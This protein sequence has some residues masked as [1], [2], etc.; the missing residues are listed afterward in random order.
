MDEPREQ[1]NQEAAANLTLRVVRGPTSKASDD[2]WRVRSDRL[3]AWLLSEWER[4]HAKADADRR[5]RRS[6]PNHD[7]RRV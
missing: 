7:Q 2:R 6:T 4:E 3:G 1:D 5:D